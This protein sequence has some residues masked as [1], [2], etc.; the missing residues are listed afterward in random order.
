M[1]QFNQFDNADPFSTNTTTTTT[2]YR[3]PYHL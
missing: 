1:D 2:T 3:R